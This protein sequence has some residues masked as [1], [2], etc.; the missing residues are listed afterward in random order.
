MLPFPHNYSHNSAC[1]G[2]QLLSSAITLVCAFRDA[3]QV[4]Q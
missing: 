2:A 4:T 1:S 3:P